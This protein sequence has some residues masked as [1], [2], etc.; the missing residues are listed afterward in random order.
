MPARRVATAHGRAP[1][2]AP[3]RLASTDHRDV[4]VARGLTRRVDGA[5]GALARRH[6]RDRVTVATGRSAWASC[7]RPV[8]AEGNVSDLDFI[9]HTGNPHA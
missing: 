4:L 1:P 6:G 3:H 7:G 9:G 5:T 2:G 8:H